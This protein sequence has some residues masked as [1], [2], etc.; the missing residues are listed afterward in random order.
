MRN[1]SKACTVF[2]FAGLVLIA[3]FI[4][5]MICSKDPGA[6]QRADR[7]DLALTQFLQFCTAWKIPC[8]VVGIPMFLIS[9]IVSLVKGKE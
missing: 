9:A 4:A 1:E 7:Y 8:G 3:F 6:F 5:G 2:I